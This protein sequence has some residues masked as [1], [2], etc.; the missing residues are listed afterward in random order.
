MKIRARFNLIFTLLA[1][2]ILLFFAASVYWIS[3][4]NRQKEFNT[5]LENEAQIKTNLFIDAN[6]S[7]AHLQQIYA[8]QSENPNTIHIAI[9]NSEQKELYSDYPDG[10]S[11]DSIQNLL[12]KVKTDAKIKSRKNIEQSIGMQINLGDND[13]IILASGQDIYGQQKLNELL[14]ILIFTAIIAII[15]LYVLGFYFSKRVLHPVTEMTQEINKITAAHL[16][17]RLKPLKYK[18]ELNDLG[19]IFNQMLDRLE[20]SFDSQKEFVAHISHELRTPLAAMITDLELALSHTQ[21]EKEYKETIERSLSDAQKIVKLSNNLLDLAKANY[22]PQEVG[23]TSLRIDEILLEAYQ[24]IQM[25]ASACSVQ[26]EFATSNTDENLMTVM[27]NPYLLKVA[28]KN[29]IENAC[30]F[31]AN[32]HCFISIGFNQKMVK[33]D[34]TDKGI[35]ITEEELEHIFTPFY[36]G[37]SQADYDGYGIGLPLTQKILFQHNGKLKVSTTP[38]Q[39]STFTLYIPHLGGGL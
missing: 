19:A 34:F 21:T 14:Y 18:D 9:Y 6:L 32:H 35:G 17:L 29:L 38:E 10:E 26:M 20:N 7:P 30:K 11:V 37:N 8:S 3:K 31:S 28:C 5:I 39:G 12:Q 23:Y 25:G 4:K 27:G 15:I 16:D 22:D 24:E 36:R 1:T 2:S 33:V 13:F